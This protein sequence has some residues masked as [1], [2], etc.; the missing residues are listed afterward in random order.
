MFFEFMKD[1]DIELAGISVDIAM[2]AAEI[3]AAYKDFKAMDSYQLAV[4]LEKGCD[5][6]LTNDK[7]LRQFNELKCITVDEWELSG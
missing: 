6:F 3:R 5:V 4:A 2:N 1:C 7:Q